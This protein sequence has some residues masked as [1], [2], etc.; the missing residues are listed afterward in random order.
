MMVRAIVTQFVNNILT[1][2]QYYRRLSFFPVAF[3]VSELTVLPFN[4]IW[5]LSKF[6]VP[7][8]APIMKF[9]LALRAA[10]FLTLRAPIGVFAFMYSHMQTPGGF[11]ELLRR[12]FV[13]K[14]VPTLLAAGTTINTIAFSIFNL[15]WTIQAIK[16]SLKVKSKRE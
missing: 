16:A 2:L 6:N 12:I 11:R 15:L 5:Y 14:E 7:R 10:A 8:T 9:A 13:T 1:V 3:T 4:L